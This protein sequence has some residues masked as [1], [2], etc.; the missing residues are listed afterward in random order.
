MG[1][2]AWLVRIRQRSQRF[3]PQA[4]RLIAAAAAGTALAFMLL[5]FLPFRERAGRAL[6]PLLRLRLPA[7]AGLQS[8][9]L[10]LLLI[11]VAILTNFPWKL[12]RSLR[13][14]LITSL[15]W[16][17]VP[18]VVVSWA[19]Y[20]LHHPLLALGSLAFAA[21]LIAAPSLIAQAPKPPEEGRASIL[22]PD[23]PVPE[24]GRDLLD[25]REL[26]DSVVSTI[27][28]EPPPIIAVTGKYGDG[29]TSFL[30]LVLGELSKSQEIE[31]PIIVRFSPWL[32]GDSNAL[33]LSLLTSIVAS[34]KRSLFVPG[35][36]GDAT[37]YARTLLSAVPWTEKLKDL[38]GEPSQE[39]RIDA[40]VKRIARVR[41]RVLVV[42]DDL[43]RMEAKELET[44]LKVLRGSD[45]LSNITF[46]C[47][48]DKG[49]VSL[50][51]KKTRPHQETSVFIEKF[52]PVEFRLPEIGS[53]QLRTFFAQRVERALE[54]GG[55]Q[56]EDLAKSGEQAW[57]SGLGQ[58]F[59]NLRKIKVFFN[60]INRSL[61]LIA[62]EVNV[63]DFVRLE[64]IRDITPSLYGLIFR[65]P[66]RFWEGGLAF[67][68]WTKSPTRYDEDRAGKS[69]AEFYKNNVETIVDS[70]QVIQLL[71]NLF[72]YF[73]AF[74]QGSKHETPSAA[75]AER[76]KRLFHPRYFWQYFLLKVPSQLF[77]QK[78]FSA[79]ISSLQRLDEEDV[80]QLFSKSFRSII[81][82]DFKRWY[83][84]HLIEGRFDELSPQV[85]RGLCRGMARNSSLWSLDAFELL[86]AVSC[87]HEALRATTDDAERRAFLHN[88]IQ[89]SESDLYALILYW[90]LE[91][92]EK[93]AQGKL[94][95][96]LQEARAPL[97]D[98]LRSHY[99]NPGAPSVFQQY[100][101]LGTGGI[102]PNQFLFSW[103]ALDAK[104]K[105]DARDYLRTLF[106]RS[107]E[108]LDAFLKLMFR[109]DFIDDYTILKPLIDYKEL[110]Q[111]IGLNERTLDPEKVRQFRR[112]YE[113]EN[114]PSA[115]DGADA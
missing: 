15:D 56:D 36:S 110:S 59:P 10:L 87:T 109:V 90:R 2:R 18:S 62:H 29:K 12:W 53:E 82:E 37:R 83:F 76:N 55:L 77:S 65:N 57:D 30:N 7:H 101:K 50:I 3:V 35:L 86:T 81:S 22:E 99:L 17:L 28:L 100:G 60:R 68:V 48:F 107:P 95:P 96:D 1:I 20:E 40:L 112:R 23:L 67:E 108:D 69:R 5:L 14:G 98:R 44:V 93:E 49:E 91:K 70:P 54:R 6:E 41:R 16:I 73:A 88:V 66:D 31:V 115:E 63:W 4:I 9:L 58:H 52:F 11:V 78:E 84:M 114:T 74:R 79:F 85:K 32:A 102:E 24:G 19:A 51:L 34:V 80:A 64:L 75:E 113:A 46:L 26:I 47:A 89:D 45:K 39:G 8:A 61:E 72:P 13:L 38:I 25:R 105:G 106:R 43:D 42:L 92:L 27:L 111:M 94:L 21:L 104:A 103:Q 97:R 71:S 33:V